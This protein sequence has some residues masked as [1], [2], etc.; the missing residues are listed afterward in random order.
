MTTP[1]PAPSR[2]QRGVQS[3]AATRWASWLLSRILY[4]L[5]RPLLRLTHGRL[6]V[7][8]LLT[9]LPVALLTSTGA[10]SGIPRTSPL[11]YLEDGERVVLIASFFGR[12][13]HPAWYHNLRAH[14]EATLSMGR[15]ECAYTAR[16]LAGEERE[17]YWRQAIALYPGY[18]AYERRAGGRRIPVLLLTPKSG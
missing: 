14:P 16:E 1:S 15:R 9:G 18:A 5:D 7:A 17:G 8:G 12:P 2:L 13:H 3:L 10:R 6:S 4:R 11:V